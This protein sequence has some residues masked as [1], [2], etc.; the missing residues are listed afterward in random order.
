MIFLEKCFFHH[1]RTLNEK[2]SATS[3]VSTGPALVTALYSSRET[4]WG[5]VNSLRNFVFVNIL[6]HWT[7]SFRPSGKNCLA[8]SSKLHSTCPEE[9]F[10][11]FLKK[12]DVLN[13]IRTLSDYRS[14]YWLNFPNGPWKLLPTFRE[15]HFTDFFLFLNL[16]WDFSTMRY[17]IS[18]LQ[19]K[20]SLQGFQTCILSVRLFFENL[21]TAFWWLRFT[22][23]E[24]FFEENCFFG[25]IFNFLTFSALS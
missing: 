15:E 13:H 25:K 12:L 10:G 2:I 6:G 3:W 17:K 21:L 1:F 14:A 16:Y 20:I 11:V 22:F 9:H 7:K 19:A 18:S 5:Q 23:R 8:E 24:K 4:L